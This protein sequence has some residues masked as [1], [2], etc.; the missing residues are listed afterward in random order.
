MFLLCG[1]QYEFSWRIV[2]SGWI[3]SDDHILTN[4]YQLSISEAAKRATNQTADQP[5]S[6]LPSSWSSLLSQGGNGKCLMCGAY[7]LA[8][9][10]Q[11]PMAKNEQRVEVSCCS[12]KM[13][14]NVIKART[15]AIMNKWLMR[16]FCCWFTRENL[17][18]TLNIARSKL[19]AGESVSMQSESPQPKPFDLQPFRSN[20]VR[21]VFYRTFHRKKNPD[22]LSTRQL[23]NLDWNPDPSSPVY[24]MT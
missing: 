4:F 21:A 8:H 12:G 2:S 17:N 1:L 9:V 7:R 22:K 19:V 3:S 5:S 13:C 16:L 10:V 15:L 23:E 11:D 24:A 18:L 6:M 14:R 20:P